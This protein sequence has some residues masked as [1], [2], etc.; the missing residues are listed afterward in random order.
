[1]SYEMI[2]NQ[3]AGAIPNTEWELKTPGL[4]ENTKKMIKLICRTK[5]DRGAT[6]RSV[7]KYIRKTFKF[8]VKEHKTSESSEKVT[9]FNSKDHKYR[10]IYKPMSGGMTE[11]TL[12]SSITELFPC[13]AFENKIKTKN[14]DH[15][16]GAVYVLANVNHKCYT[17]IKNFEAGQQFIEDA[18]S[19]SK[20]VEKIKNAIAITQFIYD[21]DKKKKVK[22][23]YWTYRP[24]K[25]KG[26]PD[27][28]PA[29]IVLEF[30]DGDMLGVSLKAG[31]E[32]TAEPLLNTYVNPIY[33]FFYTGTGKKKTLRKKLWKN[34]YSKIEGI[35]EKY[36][37]KANLKVTKQQ[38]EYFEDNYLDEYEAMYDSNLNI[39]R[40]D[41]MKT[42]TSDV[43]KFKDYCYKQIMKKSDLPTIIIKAVAKTYKE[44]EDS[45]QLATLLTMT[46]SVKAKKSTTSKQNFNICLY[47]K[48]NRLLGEMKMS[49]RSN[50]VGV[51]HKLGQFFNLA[52]KYNGLE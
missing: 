8:K 28:S 52:V 10:V 42:L 34:S 38:L 27:N 35:N 33:D 29:D 50:K 51:D 37:E 46:E 47:D 13:I 21:T 4:P 2:A 12:N 41:L 15:F 36:D 40:D 17:S 49:V 22:Q 5:A 18:D 26:V 9:S 19:S 16:Y 24:P 44:V 25:P 48:S 45:S 32:K 23:T 31:G 30:D 6:R 14:V 1:M 3:I 7:Q 11:T 39:I 20:F 43:D